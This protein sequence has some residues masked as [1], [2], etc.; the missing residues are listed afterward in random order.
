MKEGRALRDTVRDRASELLGAAPQ[1]PEKQGMLSGLRPG[2]ETSGIKKQAEM[3]R[4]HQQPAHSQ[5][6]FFF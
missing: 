1:K 5:D 3:Q 4:G 6:T 2:E